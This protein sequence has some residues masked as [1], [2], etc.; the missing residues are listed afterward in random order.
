[1]EE[2]RLTDNVGRIIDFKNT[3]LILT[4]NIGAQDIT[5]RKPFGYTGGRVQSAESTYAEM[6]TQLKGA[7]EKEFRP[8][9]LNRLDDIIVFRGLTPLDLTQI[10]EI[11]LSKVKKRLAEKELKL[12]LTDEARDL[13][14][15]KGTNTEY[16]ARPL[17]RAIE[18]NLEDPLSEDLLRGTFDGKNVIKVIVV[19]GTEPGEKKLAFEA[20]ATTENKELVL[21]K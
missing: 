4:T 1:M 21:A 12:E 17:R 8:E 20:I 5:G 11:E 10:V 15:E 18:Q 2:G 16:G 14:I 9:F 13:L 19:P 3:I 6:K 7:M